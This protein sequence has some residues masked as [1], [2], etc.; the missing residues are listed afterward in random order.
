MLRTCKPLESN[1]FCAISQNRERPR[2]SGSTDGSHVSLE[3]IRKPISVGWEERSETHR[4]LS[5]RCMMGFA[6]LFPSYELTLRGLLDHLVGAGGTPCPL[7]DSL[8]SCPPTV[9]GSGSF[10]ATQMSEREGRKF[11]FFASG[12][13][14]GVVPHRWRRPCHR[15]CVRWV[16]HRARHCCGDGQWAR[17]S[18]LYF[19]GAVRR[20]S[21]A[22][23]AVKPVTPDTA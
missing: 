5:Q 2:R 12:D 16:R 7:R 13:P 15:S 1:S 22:F 17:L 18:V 20:D 9:G 23:A 11:F 6:A 4:F 3:K 14:T 21:D 8:G 10:G 19:G